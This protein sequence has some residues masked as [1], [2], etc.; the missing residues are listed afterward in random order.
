[1]ILDIIISIALIS[2]F[3]VAFMTRRSI[4][5]LTKNLEKEFQSSNSPSYQKNDIHTILNDRLVD[6]QHRKYSL[7]HTHKR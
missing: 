1:M 2:N 5:L 3:F 7:Q 4:I 6:I